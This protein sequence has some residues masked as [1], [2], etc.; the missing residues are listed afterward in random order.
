MKILVRAEK[1]ENVFVPRKRQGTKTFLDVPLELR[2]ADFNSPAGRYLM[3][4]LPPDIAEAFKKAVLETGIKSEEAWKWVEYATSENGRGATSPIAQW[5]CENPYNPKAFLYLYGEQDALSPLDLG[6]IMTSGASAIYQRLQS[7]IDRLPGIILEE[8]KK[9][10][11]KDTEKYVIYNVGSAFSLDTIYMMAENPELHQL[12]RVVCI[13]PDYESLECG[14]QYAEKLGI[15]QFI[16]FIP[17]KVEETN[18]A[19]AHMVLFIGMFCPVPTEACKSTLSFIGN[20]IADNGIVIFSTVQE[21]MLMGGPILD[22]IMW[23]YGWRM[24]FKSDDEPGKIVASAGLL[25]EK[26]LDWEDDY[27]YNRMTVARKI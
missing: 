26:Q 10:G 3:K 20:F 5:V 22:F 9:V 21:K 14:R 27:G 17:K 24:Y 25:H 13:D 7:L 19:Q 23:S 6:Y 15:D 16:E 12:V 8:R 4:I 2:E 18:I 11:L 1:R